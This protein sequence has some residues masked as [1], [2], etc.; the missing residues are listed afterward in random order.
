MK[1]FLSMDAHAHIRPTRTALELSAAGVVLAVT[2]SL[3]EA[4]KTLGREEP[5]IVWG[6]GCHPRE[7]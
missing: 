3:D 7:D 2:L 4:R 6:V 5:Y 1:P